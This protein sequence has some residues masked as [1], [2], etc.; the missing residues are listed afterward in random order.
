MAAL[1]REF[2]ARVGGI[3][4]GPDALLAVRPGKIRLRP[5][6][7]DLRLPVTIQDVLYLGETARVVCASPEAGVV[8]VS[9]DPDEAMDLTI[10]AP[11]TVG[12]APG[13]TVVVSAKEESA[14][15]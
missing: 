10:Q 12:F 9:A 7:D 4:E 1:G 5:A 13:D 8:L 3:L 6:P 11:L 2:A 15:R 14:C